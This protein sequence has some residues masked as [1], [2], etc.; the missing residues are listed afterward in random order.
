MIAELFAIRDPRAGKLEFVDQ[1]NFFIYN[2]HVLLE[3]Y[4]IKPTEYIF[5]VYIASSE[6]V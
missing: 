6:R 4:F 2:S 1:E 5:R 3:K